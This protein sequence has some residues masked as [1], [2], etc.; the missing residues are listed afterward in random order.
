MSIVDDLV[1][2]AV[3]AGVT[4]AYP[5]NGVP[6][7]PTYPYV[8]I[9]ADTGTPMNRRLGGGTDR[10]PRR[11]TVQIFGKTEDAVLDIADKADAAF[12]DKVLGTLAGDPF[13]MREMQTPIVRDPDA[14]GVLNIL[15]TYKLLE[16]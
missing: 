6:A 11:F 15:H 12:E 7:G 13:S 4:R 1:G 2:L 8:V 10:K 16:A 5:I 14:T 9:G 3:A